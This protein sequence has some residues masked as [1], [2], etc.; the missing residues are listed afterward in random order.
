MRPDSISHAFERVCGGR[1]EDLTFHDLRHAA[2]SRFFGQGFSLMEVTAITGH[3][4]LSMLMKC[5]AV[6]WRHPTFRVIS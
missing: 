2:T 4:A 3:S 6:P 5:R 1:G